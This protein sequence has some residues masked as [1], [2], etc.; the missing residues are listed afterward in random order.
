MNISIYSPLS[1]STYIELSRRLRN[2]M[3]GQ[4]NI[5]SNNNK[6]FLWCHIRHLSPLKIYPKRITIANKNMINDVDYKGIEFLISKKD[7][8][9]IKKKNNICINVFC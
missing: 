9:K 7:F 2:S 3:K 5:K 6:C 4:L 8:G 1:G